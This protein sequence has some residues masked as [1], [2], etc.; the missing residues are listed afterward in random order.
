[1]CFAP[2]TFVLVLGAKHVSNPVYRQLNPILFI[3]YDPIIAKALGDE[4]VGGSSQCH[5]A[6]KSAFAKLEELMEDRTGAG[7][8]SLMKTFHV[9]GEVVTDLDCWMLHDYVSDDFMGLVQYGNHTV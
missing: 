9:C 7:R 8:K 5:A 4:F 2:S 6:V 3:G 1:M